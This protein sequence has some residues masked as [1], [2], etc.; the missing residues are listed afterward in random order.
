[1]ISKQILF[2]MF[3]HLFVYL[4]CFFFFAL[5]FF[6]H[7]FS[8]KVRLF[9]QFNPFPLIPVD[10]LLEQRSP[11]AENFFSSCELLKKS[12]LLVWIA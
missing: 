2:P 1:M 10:S 9:I 5:F 8:G 12:G 7:Q 4:F 3:V 6:L 11:K